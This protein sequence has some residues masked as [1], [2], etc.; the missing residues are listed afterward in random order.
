MPLAQGVSWYVMNRNLDYFELIREAKA[1]PENDS[2]PALKIA[3]LSDAA[4]QQFV[5]LLRA[6]FHRHNV[7]IQLY[8]GSFDGI[9]LAVYN[10]S[11]ALY[12]FEPDIV[13]LLNAAQSL[14]TRYYARPG[15]ALDWF[16]EEQQRVIR[17]WDLLRQTLPGLVIQSNFVLPLERLFGNFDHKVPASYYR[18]VQKLN[19]SLSDHAASRSNVLINDVESIASWVGRRNWFDE[20]LWNLAKTFCAIEHLPLVAKNIVDISLA[21]RGRGV[22]CVVLDLDNTLWGGTVGDEGAHGIQLAAHGEGEAFYQFQAYLRELKRRGILLA[23]CS[24]NEYE[25]AIRPFHENSEMVLQVADVAAFIAN[26]DNKAEN[27]RKIAAL[28]EIGLDSL[29][30]LDDNPFERNLVRD[31][32]PEVSVPDL[33]EDPSDYVKALSELNLF[34]TSAFSS[35][36]LLRSESY[37]REVDRKLGETKAASFDEFLQSLDMRIEI[38]RFAPPQIPRIAQLIQRS[39]QFNLTTNRYNQSECERMMSDENWIPL[40]AKLRDRFG[41]HGLI[42]IVVAQPRAPDCVL[43]ITDWLMS[44]R[45]MSRGVEDCLMNHVFDEAKRRSLL[46]VVGTYVPSAK[47]GMVKDFFSRFGFRKVEEQANGSSS[48]ELAVSEYEPRPVYLTSES[49]SQPLSDRQ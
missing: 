47:N 17:I 28:L 10:R 13:V 9:E 39:N 33:P 19:A 48:W 26:W 22:K 2:P 18:L 20:R 27:I 38:G 30:Y 5:P 4:T 14:R 11:S 29:V 49:G 6:L 3:L 36:D 7:P 46:T 32:V 12:E 21:T 42:S 44:C 34:E 31:L 23:V 45:V 8:E 24:K 35:E 37:Q 1:V 41:D 40:Y 25:N 15:E 43:K 16:D